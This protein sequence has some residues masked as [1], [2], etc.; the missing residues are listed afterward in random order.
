MTK[1]NK[2]LNDVAR[3]VTVMT[4]CILSTLLLACS[5]NVDNENERKAI[6]SQSTSKSLYSVSLFQQSEHKPGGDITTRR[7]Y[8]SFIYPGAKLSAQQQ[9][10]FWS[11]FSFFRDPWV[12]APSATANRDGLGPLFN[13]RSCIACHTAGSRAKIDVPKQ[14]SNE[15]L[16]LS[17]VV[18]LGSKVA[19]VTD[20]D[21]IYGGQIQPRST[22]YRLLDSSQASKINSNTKV[23][24]KVK[25][26]DNVGEAWLK[27]ASETIIGQFDDGQAYELIKP[28]YQLSRLA[29]GQLADNT[30]ISVRLAPNVFGVGLLNAIH[31]DDLIAQED[32][33]DTNNDGVSA[34]YNRVINVV[35]GKTELGR[36]G[37]KAKQPNLHQQVAA[38][39][40]D[41]IGITNSSFSEDSCTEQQVI[42]QQ[43]SR[44]GGHHRNNLEIPDN[45]LDITVTF[46]E[47]LGVPPARNLDNKI[48]QQGRTH[49][50]QLNCQQCHTPSYITDKNYPVQALANQ[51]IWPYT[52]LA[53]HDM[54]ADLADGVFEF[55][56]TGTEWRTPPLW[57]IG[58]QKKIT[59]QQRFLHD[60]RARTI[61]EAILWH[62]GEAEVSQQAYKALSENQRLALI[63]FI[64][65]I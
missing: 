44:A 4:L 25:V 10:D 17:L 45:R 33:N 19:G 22:S 21:P 23:K 28:N 58:L 65:A 31:R 40:R 59:G 8:A 54:G 24:A 48:I 37:F 29:Y 26:K 55:D 41:D 53:L 30:G 3:N 34:K 5:D 32:I 11:G 6:S 60:G 63:K 12:A 36:F 42:C 61:S 14:G 39:F 62:G 64:R 16:P 50:Y 1:L 46:N 7:L 35:N 2:G 18:R 9:L 13:T 38:A 43:A 20:S 52:D 27:L 57:G 49:F 15:V 51:T 47:L 56:A